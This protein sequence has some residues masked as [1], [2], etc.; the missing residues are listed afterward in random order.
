MCRKI[1]AVAQ[2]EFS[3]FKRVKLPFNFSAIIKIVGLIFDQ[4]H[5]KISLHPVC[6]ALINMGIKHFGFTH[7]KVLVISVL[8][9]ALCIIQNHQ[10]WMDHVLYEFALSSITI[11]TCDI[12]NI[13]SHA[14]NFV[15]TAN[16]ESLV[17]VYAE[18]SILSFHFI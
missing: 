8:V 4:I 1:I 14:V 15:C 10:L 7:D 13:Q 2:T 6:S 12:F 18:Q 11:L 5:A 17:M 9:K 3:W 16:L